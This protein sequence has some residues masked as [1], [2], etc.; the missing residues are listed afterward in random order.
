[1][2]ACCSNKV[3]SRAPEAVSARHTACAEQVARKVFC[4]CVHL[5]C[6]VIHR[7][8]TEASVRPVTLCAS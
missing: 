5:L 1:M 3:G 7:C 6:P 4:C 8:C 2:R